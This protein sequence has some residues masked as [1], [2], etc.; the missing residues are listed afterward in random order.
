MTSQTPIVLDS[1]AVLAYLQ[2]EKGAQRVI[3]ILA[4]AHDRGAELLM[5]T[6][7]AGEVWYISAQRSGPDQADRALQLIQSLC[8]K[9]V[10]ADWAATKIAAGY[11]AQG[12]ISYADCFAAALTQQNGATLVTGDPGDPESRK[13]EKDLIIAWL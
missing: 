6:I 10:D 2:G 11:K 7:N 13:L 12:G 3:E 9:I 1:W 8:I 4:D 5:C